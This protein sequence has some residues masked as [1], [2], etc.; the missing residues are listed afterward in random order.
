MERQKE[1][2]KRKRGREI[3]KYER[4]KRKEILR[5]I[6]TLKSLLAD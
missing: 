1:R 4:K 6:L 5:D 2:R 3:E